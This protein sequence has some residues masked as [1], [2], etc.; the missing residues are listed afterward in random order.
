MQ[1][2]DGLPLY[3]FDKLERGYKGKNET[4]RSY[5]FTELAVLRAF[6]DG[7]IG[8]DE[9]A[10]AITRPISE[11]PML[12]LGTYNDDVL[13]LVPLWTLY[14][15]ALDE[16]PSS[17]IQDLI[18]LG[19]AISKLLDKI[20]QGEAT[21]DN[22]EP[23]TWKDLPYFHMAWSDAHWK[24]PA[25]ILKEEMD[26]AA[27]HQAR[28]VYVRQQKVE[29]QLVAAGLLGWHV[30]GRV[31]YHALK[32]ESAIPGQKTL[33]EGGEEE[34]E[35]TKR[36]MSKE[37][38]EIGPLDFHIVAEDYWIEYVGDRVYSSLVQKELEEE[39]R[40]SESEGQ[41]QPS[42]P[43]KRWEYLIDHFQRAA[44]NA[45]DSSTREMA[46]ATIKRMERIREEA[47]AV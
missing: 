32:Q 1:D 2:V 33:D 29:A 11:S 16:W 10:P 9:A 36:I 41:H 28:D 13:A 45:L 19:L 25:Y 8:P 38:D 44:T 30:A 37:R 18:N 4:L 35:E 39:T 6:H 22:Y 42:Q 12:V 7:K 23:M 21:D 17:R 14:T 15:K 34:E 26:G 40:R 31:L 43:L 20:H 3:W 46:K 24:C 47:R 27:K 5:Y